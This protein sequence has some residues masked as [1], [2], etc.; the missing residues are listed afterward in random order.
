MATGRRA[1]DDGSSTWARAKPLFLAAFLT[2][3][4][5]AALRVVVELRS[6]LILLFISLVLAA[7]MSRPAAWLERRGLPRG[8][9][10]ALVQLL[11]LGVLLVVGYIVLPPLVDEVAGFVKRVPTYVD[12]FQGLRRDYARIRTNYPELGSFDSEVS[13]LADRAGSVVGKRLINLPLG[14]ASLLYEALTVVAF[15]TLIVMRRERIVQAILPLVAPHRREHTVA[16]VDTIWERIGAYVRAKLIV[17]TIVGVLMY[18]AL[19]ALGV[20]FAVPLAVIVAFGEIIPQI[21]PW[22]ARAPLL[23][24]AAFEGPTTLGLTFLASFILENLKAYVISPR[25]EGEQL[26]LDP[27]LVLIAVLAGGTLLGA[28]GALVSVPFAATL[29][30]LYDEILVPWRRAQIVEDE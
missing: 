30:V 20:P 12:R 5:I 8:L 7:A 22:I 9:A 16:I 4:T 14:L 24:V 15:S 27:L 29:Q 10:V 19:I 26:K 13:K 18:L 17:M 23:A 2:I 25:V 1:P 11:A 28:A 21:G 3:L 6:L